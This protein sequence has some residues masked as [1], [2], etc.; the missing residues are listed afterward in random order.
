[1]EIVDYD[2]YVDVYGA[3]EIDDELFDTLTKRCEL[4]INSLVTHKELIDISETNKIAYKNAICAQIEYLSENTESKLQGN[5]TNSY[6][7]ENYPS[8]S[9]T[10]NEKTVNTVN[11]SGITIAPLAYTYL[12]NAGLL[13]RG[14]NYV[15]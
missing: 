11:V 3:K 12:N 1:M 15:V 5:D 4:L 9:Y 10:R 13:Y 14:V 8:Y 6:L 7:S 2:Y